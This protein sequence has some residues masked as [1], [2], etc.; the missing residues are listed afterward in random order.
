MQRA[1]N[2]LAILIVVKN[3]IPQLPELSAF[4]VE[5]G[6]P[7]NLDVGDQVV[8]LQK[9][10]F[11]QLSVLL[12]KEMLPLVSPLQFTCVQVGQNEDYRKG[13]PQVVPERCHCVYILAR[14]NIHLDDRPKVNQGGG[15]DKSIGA[16]YQYP[17]D[18]GVG[19]GGVLEES[20]NNAGEEE[21][22]LPR[23]VEIF[24]DGVRG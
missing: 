24:Y 8:A 11:R 13:K 18:G 3:E 4:D 14:S 22:D 12:E 5:L 1:I 7:D 20:K 9:Q 17:A 2:S 16:Y 6:L 21:D 10:L 19:I 23:N 15:P